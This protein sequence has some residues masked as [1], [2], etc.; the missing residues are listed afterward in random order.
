MEHAQLVR[1]ADRPRFAARQVTASLQPIHLPSDRS[2]A[3]TCWGDRLDDA[4]AWRSLSDAGALIAL[5]S[6]APIETANPWRGIFAA[7]RR[8]AIGDGDDP[9]RPAEALTLD[10]ALAGY[11]IGPSRAALRSDLGH[12]RPGAR[13]DLAILN[14]DLETLRA[15]DARLASVHSQLTLV[16]GTEVHGT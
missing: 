8:H 9:W 2:S 12:L 5:G 15:A 13:A 10:E 3:E 1:A 7:V 4:Y 16:D 6:D 14:V 11:T